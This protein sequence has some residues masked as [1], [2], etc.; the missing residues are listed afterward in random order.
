MQT[1]S[2]LH[3]A[4]FL[5]A[6]LIDVSFDLHSIFCKRIDLFHLMFITKI[7]LH[8]GFSILPLLLAVKLQMPIGSCSLNKI[9]AQKHKKKVKGQQIEVSTSEALEE[10]DEL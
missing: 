10:E 1:L 5:Y 2:P 6:L 7:H 3:K 8:F 9:E 4:Y